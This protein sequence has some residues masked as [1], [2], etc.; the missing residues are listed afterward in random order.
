MDE[1]EKK[2]TN[3]LSAD[4]F[5]A[6]KSDVVTREIGKMYDKKMKKLKIECWLRLAAA[7]AITVYGALGIKY[8]TGWYVTWALFTAIVGFNS[9]VAIILWYWQVHAR[10][11][12]LK[13]IKQLQL[14]I[15]ELTG[16]NP[17]PEN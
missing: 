12:V 11:T 8:N 4:G 13:E 5:N 7:V 17:S 16:K 15:A 2:L 10:L 1:F 9:V 14:Q 3:S 6:E